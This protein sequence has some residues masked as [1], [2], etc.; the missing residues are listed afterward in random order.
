MKRF[1]KFL[2]HDFLIRKYEVKILRNEPISKIRA[3]KSM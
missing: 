2:F 3:I 1:G